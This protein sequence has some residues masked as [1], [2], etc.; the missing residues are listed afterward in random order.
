MIKESVP[1]FNVVIS[2]SLTDTLSRLS[3]GRKPLLITSAGF[4]QRGVVDEVLASLPN[5]SF[6]VIE[7]VSPNPE[8][9]YLARIL[10]QYQRTDFTS[11]IALGGG[12]VMDSAKVLSRMLGQSSAK[13]EEY[14]VLRTALPNNEPIPLTTIPTSSGTGAEIT[15]FATVWDS[16]TQ[17]KYSFSDRIPDST[18]LVANLTQTL[19]RNETLYS[20]L[21]ALSHAL[22]SLWNNQRTPSS[23][24]AALSAID[25]VLDGLPRVLATPQSLEARKTMLVGANLAGMAIT[26]TRTALAHAM[27]YSLTLKY[28]IP[29]GLACSFTLPALLSLFKNEELGLSSAQRD[30]LEDLLSSL[31]LV[32]EVTHFA[33]AEQIISEYDYDLEPSRAK[34]FTRPVTSAQIKQILLSSLNEGT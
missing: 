5:C 7:D 12:S 34:N 6:T 2:E 28:G 14:L 8:L 4:R 30:G 31:K 17:T 25:H 15:P 13:L 9:A 18:I 24:K 23:Q 21:D 26:E 10:E 16:R 20:G 11:I 19:P 1:E 33:S 22:E 27:S 32:D 3:L 29:H